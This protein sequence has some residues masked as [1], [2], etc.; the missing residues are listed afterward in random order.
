MVISYLE[1]TRNA[2]IV[3]DES[4]KIFNTE[5]KVEALRLLYDEVVQLAEA[6]YK[7][8]NPLAGKYDGNALKNKQIVF[9]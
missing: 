5:E 4:R 6:V 9:F 8:I 1:D 3:P 2:L 7:A